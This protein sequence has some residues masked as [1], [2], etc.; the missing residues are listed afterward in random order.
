M[1]LNMALSKNQDYITIFV[2][3]D[4]ND[5]LKVI[6]VCTILVIFFSK[7]I[8]IVLNEFSSCN[9]KYVNNQTDML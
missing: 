4:K 3:S 8:F 7:F 5:S 6:C 2:L 1:A 9:S